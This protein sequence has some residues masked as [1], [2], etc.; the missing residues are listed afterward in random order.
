MF[1]IVEGVRLG[2]KQHR[3]RQEQHQR[4]DYLSCMETVPVTCR[5]GVLVHL[6][7]LLD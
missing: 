1:C 3:S 2:A 5:E 4:T 7:V 6:L